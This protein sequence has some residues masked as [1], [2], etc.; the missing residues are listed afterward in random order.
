MELNKTYWEN[1]YLKNETGWDAGSITKPLKEYIDQLAN[2]DLKILI[3]GA[4]NGYEFD[5]LIQNGF[6]NIFVV[7]IA[8]LPLETIKKRNPEYASQMIHG[9]FF[10]VN[11]TFDLILEQTF[12]CALH[13]GLRTQYVSKMSKLLKPKGKLIG[14]LFDFPLTSEGPP[15]GGSYEEYTAL[16]SNEF[17]L[18]CLEK[19]YNSI[20]PREGKEL[21]FIF[22]KK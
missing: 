20:K 19:S 14:L 16:F 2:K 8:A 1:R 21:F 5:Y 6:T 7:D 4:G 17:N 18:K 22:E 13:P 12:F 11:D 9:D 15:F 3:P 10:E